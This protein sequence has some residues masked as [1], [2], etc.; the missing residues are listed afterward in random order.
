MVT[1][2]TPTFLDLPSRQV[3][4][5]AVGRTHTLDKGVPLS[6]VEGNVA[7]AGHLVDLVKIGWGIGYVDP[8]IAER[9]A[10]YRAAGIAVSLGGTIMEVAAAQ[11]K[12]DELI[13]WALSVGVD[14]L[15]V[16]DGLDRLSRSEKSALISRVGARITVG[17]E[18]GSKSASSLVDADEWADQ[19]LADLDAGA[20]WVIAEGRESGTVGLYEENG[21]VRTDLVDRLISRVPLKRIVFEAPTKAQQTWFVRQLG[22]DVN[23]SNIPADEVL[24]LETLRLGLRADTADLSCPAVSR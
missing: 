6:V 24:P 20:R 1:S 14:T 12:V 21:S 5:R 17:A 19:M 22:A 4:P 7:Q 9:T 3:K 10:L 13:D 11:N 2:G 8:Q 16:S 23:L 15:E 18:V